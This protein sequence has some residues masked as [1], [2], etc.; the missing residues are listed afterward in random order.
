MATSRIA[1]AVGR[2]LGDRYRLT[3]PLGVGASAHVFVAEDVNLRRR[4]AIKILHAGLAADEPFRRRF[5]A[6]ARVAAGLRHPNILRV[7][8]WGYDAGDPY[9]VMELLEGGSLRAL[10]DRGY[11]LSPAQAAHVGADVARALDYAHRRGLVHRDIKPANLIFDDEG[12][13]TVADFGLARALAE[14]SWTEPTGAVVGTARYAAPE[15]VRGE[16]LDSRA[17]VYALALVLTEAT[18]GSVPFAA[19]TTL[20]TLLGR[21]E[22]PIAAPAGTGPL[23][24]ALEAAGTIDPSAR[25]DAIGLA[26]ALD[27][28]GAQLSPPAPLPL[29]GPVEGEAEVDPSPTDYPGRPRLFDGAQVDADDLSHGGDGPPPRSMRLRPQTD[30]SRPGPGSRRRGWW[31]PAVVVPLVIG[32]LAGGALVVW[33]T[34]AL[35]PSHPVPGLLGATTATAEQRLRPLHFHL[36]VSDRAYDAH[37]AVGTVVSQHPAGGRLR[38]GSGVTVTLSLGPRPVTIP[39]LVGLN[40]TAAT[41]LLRY[42]GLRAEV[43]GQVAS[44]TVPAGLVVSSRPAHGTLLPGQQVALVVSSGKPMVAVPPLQGANAASFAA[45]HHALSAVGLSATET[46]AYNDTV[47]AG[48]VVSTRPAAGVEGGCRLSRRRGDLERSP[49]DLR[50]QRPRRIGGRGVA[51][52]VRRRL[53]AE[54]GDRQ[55]DRH[56]DGDVPGVRGGRP[57]RV[58]RA[59]HHGLSRAGP[60]GGRSPMGG[61]AGL[62]CAA[63]GWRPPAGAAGLFRAAGVWGGPLSCR[64]PGSGQAVIA[65]SRWASSSASGLAPPLIPAAWRAIILVMSPSTLIRPPRKACIAAWASPSTRRALAVS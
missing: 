60:A 16:S 43:V 25:L 5:Q 49:P 14:A 65:C 9:L 20:A 55:P 39:G 34:G 10:L 19:D 30:R 54:R 63:G 12:R 52:A 4:V 56:G 17:D 46:T 40:S 45:A 1:D 2:V 42:L 6:E 24:P 51:D 32:L 13:I 64:G 33:A 38:E 50:P 7:Y 31:R 37:A 11:L 23:G 26:R 29:A 59:D 18:T 15:A 27:G 61:A 3:R 44:M 28:I 22:R 41:A 21:L 36:V 35:T 58:G 53:P 47:A 48:A 57:L 62:V 8:D